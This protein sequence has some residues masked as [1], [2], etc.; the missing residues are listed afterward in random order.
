VA[1]ALAFFPLAVVTKGA[2]SEQLAVAI[3]GVILELALVHK[4]AVSKSVLAVAI[5]LPFFPLALVHSENTTTRHKYHFPQTIWLPMFP[6][7]LITVSL[8]NPKVERH[9]R[10]MCARRG[11][12]GSNVERH[13]RHVCARAPS[14]RSTHVEGHRDGPVGVSLGI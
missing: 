10:R 11:A 2:V 8:N 3:S 1:M 12:R 13:C 9:W 4:S 5:S 7:S 6:S 14:L